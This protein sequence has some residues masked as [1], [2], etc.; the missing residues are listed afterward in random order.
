VLMWKG[1]GED[2]LRASGLS[3]TIV[4]PGGLGNCEAGKAGLKIGP[5]TGISGGTICRADVGLVM[6]DAL[7]NPDAAGKTVSL[8]G[9]KEAAP[10][11]WKSAWKTVAKD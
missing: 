1:K 11:A 2:H 9:D 3:Y 4:R 7:V 5:G 10:G 8:V 6:A